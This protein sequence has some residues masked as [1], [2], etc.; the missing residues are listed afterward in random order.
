ME[1]KRCAM[2]VLTFPVI[3]VEDDDKDEWA[4]DA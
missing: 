3:Q 4:D 1:A 2:V